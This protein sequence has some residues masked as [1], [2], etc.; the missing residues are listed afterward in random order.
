MK[1]TIR[2][3]NI[4]FP[5]KCFMWFTYILYPIVVPLICSLCLKLFLLAGTVMSLMM[6]TAGVITIEY[7]LDTYMFHGIVAKDYKALEYVKSSGKGIDLLQRAFLVDGIRRILTTGL[8]MTGLY[9]ATRMA[10]EKDAGETILEINGEIVSHPSALIYLQCGLIAV[11][12]VELGMLITR[13]SK[14]VLANI[15]VLY[16]MSAIACP[17]AMVAA[18]YTSSLSVGLSV[19]LLIIVMVLSRKVLVKKVR[20]SFYDEGY[21]E[22]LQTT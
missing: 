6:S 1:N 10:F 14:N 13:R 19:I 9:W 22:L 15:L 18:E 17:L 4:F 5:R 8:I 7:L 12:F 11:L 21:K 2:M 3:Y 16:V 20:E